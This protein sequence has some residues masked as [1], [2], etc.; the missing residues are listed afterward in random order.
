MHLRRVR[1]LRSTRFHLTSSFLFRCSREPLDIEA[2]WRSFM[3]DK[4]LISRDETVNNCWHD[5][6]ITLSYLVKCVSCVCTIPSH[7]VFSVL[8]CCCL[9]SSRTVYF[10]FSTFVLG[11]VAMSCWWKPSQLLVNSV[12]K[13]AESQVGSRCRILNVC[14]DLPSTSSTC[15]A[16]R[17]SR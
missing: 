3:R 1:Q 11:G 12:L 9:C 8:M 5:A 2:S 7:V 6:S 16:T 10:F 17:I 4:F 15:W 13:Q 14:T